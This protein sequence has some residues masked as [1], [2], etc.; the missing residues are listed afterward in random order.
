MAFAAGLALSGARCVREGEGVRIA[1]PPAATVDE[2][3]PS[4][5]ATPGVLLDAEHTVGAPVIIG[6]L[7]VFPVYARV[8]EDIGDFLP[9]DEALERG[10]AEVREMGAAP[11]A[12]EQVEEEPVPQ[13]IQQQAG[14]QQV[15]NQ[16][17]QRRYRNHHGYRGDGAQVNT[18]VIENRAEVP[19][20]VL[21]GTVVKGGKQDRQIGQDFIIGKKQTMPVDAFCVEHGRWNAQRNGEA[22]GG[23][24][25]SLRTLAVGDVRQAGQYQQDQGQVWAKVGKVNEATRNKTS[26][27]TLL[28]SLESPEAQA[29]RNRVGGQV[30][31]FLRKVPM[32]ERTVG[33]AYAVGGEVQGARWF[34]HHK[35]FA[36]F[37][38]TLVNTAVVDS[39]TAKAQGKAGSEGACAPEKVAAFIAGASKGREEKRKA[40]D[41]ENRYQYSDDAYASEAQMKSPTPAAAPKSVTKDFLKKK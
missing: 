25:K 35:V 29:E 39:F 38:E 17:Q 27:D 5:A 14:P 15:P 7:A 24:F 9:L 1:P 28:A 26:S 20:L 11:T 12:P 2:I 4:V 36:K 34:I 8:M 30:H 16:V 31:A 37:E 40:G 10:V 13:Q 3:P 32:A 41:N 22:T 23:S 18:L 6:N 21:A 19:I 33:L